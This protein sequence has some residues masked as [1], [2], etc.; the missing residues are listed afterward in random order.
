MNGKHKHEGMKAINLQ[1]NNYRCN[2][3]INIPNQIMFLSQIAA[4]LGL[5][6]YLL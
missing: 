3:N 5:S 2:I 1:E 6:F 4:Y